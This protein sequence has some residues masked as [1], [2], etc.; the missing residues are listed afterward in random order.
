MKRSG[1]TILEASA[2]KDVTMFGEHLRR[3]RDARGLTQQKLAE[4]A[5]L[6]KETV[7]LI[8]KGRRVPSWPTVVALAAALKVDCT[9]FQDG[10]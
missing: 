3:L 9:A 7:Y 1:A 8:E 4:A 2:M 5:K 6:T 10:R